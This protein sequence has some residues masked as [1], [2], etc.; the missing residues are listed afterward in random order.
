MTR[1]IRATRRA[2]RPLR[3]TLLCGLLAATLTVP[4]VR[5]A[6]A[7]GNDHWRHDHGHNQHRHD[8]DGRRQHH[9][10]PPP[11]YEGPNYEGYYRQP[12]VYYSAPP[13]V[14]Q[15]PNASIYFSFPLFR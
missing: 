2:F 5:P 14:Y 9:G 10:P 8:E 4:L 15:P 7:D 12:D 3:V 6:L 13:V 1:S 11:R